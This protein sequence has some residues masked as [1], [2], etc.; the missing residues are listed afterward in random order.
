MADGQFALARYEAARAAV[1]ECTRIDEAANIRDQ[2]AALAAYARQRDDKDLEGWVAEIKLRAVV[3]IGELS[4]QLDKAPPAKGHGAGI[5]ASGKT[6]AKALEDAGVSTSAAQRYEELAEA[7]AENPTKAAEYYANCKA[8]GVSPTFGGMRGALKGDRRAE[9]ERALAEKTIAAAAKL[10]DRVYSVIY[11]DPPWR[12]EP[13]SRDTGMDRAADNHYPTLTLDRLLAL[14]VPAAPD[15]VLFLWATAPMLPQA[16]AVMAAWDFAYKSHFVWLKDRMGTG[17]WNRNQHELL[18]VGTRGE[19][20]APAPGTQ[21]PSVIDAT[22]AEHSAKPHHF[23]EMI[24]E[25]FPHQTLLEMF[26]RSPRLGW[27][28]WGN[29]AG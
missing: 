18:L 7:Q 4:R 15:C 21:F 12:F 22:V 20:P 26:A 3:R 16:L 8:T 27:D 14:K 17:Y 5:P 10:G 1:A 11:A 29:E 23:A 2:A 25:M 28:V 13:Y 19:I 24:E 6:K 9:R